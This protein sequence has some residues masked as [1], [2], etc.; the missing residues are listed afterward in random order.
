M[1]KLENINKK[2]AKLKDFESIA[3]IYKESKR[4][5]GIL[6]LEIE[7][8]KKER[9]SIDLKPIEDE[10]SILQNELKDIDRDIECSR[11]MESVCLSYR[12]LE[13]VFKNFEDP[14]ICLKAALDLMK[15]MITTS[16][17][18]NS[19]ATSD[20]FINNRLIGKIKIDVEIEKLFNMTISKQMNDSII[21]ELRL[22]LKNDLEGFGPADLRL[23]IQDKY[24]II[25]FPIKEID[26]KDD[27]SSFN[28]STYSISKTD[29]KP[30][31]FRNS[32]FDE[33]INNSKTVSETIILIL[34]DNLINSLFSKNTTIEYIQECNRML[35]KTQYF[36]E[37]VD[38]WILDVYMK[39]TLGYCKS[40]NLEVV[41]PNYDDFS[42]SFISDQYASV[43]NGYNLIQN[44]N[45]KRKDK[46]RIIL[47]KSFL[48][49]FDLNNCVSI[50]DL[51]VSYSDITHF[52]RKFTFLTNLENFNI[53][54]ESLFYQILTQACDFKI[55]K[56]DLLNNLLM[57]KAK[58]KQ[59]QV[60]FEENIKDFISLK[61]QSFFRIQYFEKFIDTTLNSLRDLDTNDT[62]KDLVRGSASAVLKYILDLCYDLGPENIINYN[63]ASKLV[64]ILKDDGKEILEAE[65][66]GFTKMEIARIH[67]VFFKNV[68][69]SKKNNKY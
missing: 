58:I 59:R 33:F 11:L 30:G 9:G 56:S 19:D 46:A 17:F 53:I 5:I 57:L 51:F 67:T 69:R 40:R 62:E 45:S 34:K 6:G 8:L 60:E 13:S 32:T 54:K 49:F 47:E 25:L 23:F 16:I 7:S 31:N 2:F 37:S 41:V 50:K 24:M 38:E 42:G 22:I 52:F 55:K 35:Q 12:D 43:F 27:N 15:S 63:K 4:E 10:I 65:N 18:K 21:S 28:T 48:S 44:I 36:V 64:F 1:E 68:E 29:L 66:Y 61:T 14:E 39:R 26:S 3:K 20:V